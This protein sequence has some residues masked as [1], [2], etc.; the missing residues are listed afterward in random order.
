M[1]TPPN[2]VAGAILTAAQMN[3]IG[4]WHVKTVVGGNGA[5]SVAVTDVFGPDFNDYLVMISGGTIA[6][7]QNLRMRLGTTATGVYYGGYTLTS[8]NTGGATLSGGDN[9]ATYWNQIAY[10][11]AS[12][13]ADGNIVISNPYA[14]QRTTFNNRHSQ[15][16]TAAGAGN[17]VG[18]GFLNSATSYT[19]FTLFTTTGNWTGD[20]TITVYGYNAG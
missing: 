20:V 15:N 4:L 10:Q 7:A 11:S 19:D 5:A 9:G 1:A 18:G 12:N 3:K 16:S 17:I 2:F 6:T 13:G 8:W 14:A